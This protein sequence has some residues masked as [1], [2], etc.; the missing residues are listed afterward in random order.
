MRVWEFLVKEES[1]RIGIGT[2]LM[3]FAVKVAKEKGARMLILETQSCNVPAI[4]FY[5]KHGFRLVGYDSSAYSNE[6]I[7]KREIRIELGLML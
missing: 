1:R 3:K 2:L 7:A 6:D 4:S 5:M